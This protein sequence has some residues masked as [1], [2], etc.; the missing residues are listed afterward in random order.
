MIS[1]SSFKLNVNLNLIPSNLRFFSIFLSET[2]SLL[3]FGFFLSL[4]LSLSW[5][6]ITSKLILYF[7]SSFFPSYEF[8][9]CS[10]FFL[11]L[12]SFSFSGILREIE[13][14]EK[15][16]QYACKFFSSFFPLILSLFFSG[17]GRKKDQF[18][19]LFPPSFS[20]YFPTF[21]FLFFPLFSF[22]LSFFSYR[23]RWKEETLER[24]Q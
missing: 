15:K 23:K 13:R 11:F 5:V 21:F 19:G 9:M 24:K 18:P 12:L 7:S 1:T 16:K 22:F 10:F 8:S 6:S 17:K 14:R 2:F 4:S 3:S 20:L